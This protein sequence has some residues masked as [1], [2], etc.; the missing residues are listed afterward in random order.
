VKY[1]VLF[2]REIISVLIE[3]PVDQDPLAT[4]YRVNTIYKFLG[5]GDLLR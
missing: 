4:K 3:L 2:Y 1:I 5:I